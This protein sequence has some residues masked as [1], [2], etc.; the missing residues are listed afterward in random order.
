MIKNIIQYSI[1]FYSIVCVNSI[2]ASQVKM[3]NLLAAG[4]I[5]VIC[6]DNGNTTVILGLEKNNEWVQNPYIDA[7]SGASGFGDSNPL[8]LAMREF[9]EEARLR[10]TVPA[11]NS[12]IQF[13]KDN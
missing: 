10:Y 13:L 7:F 11:L 12:N 2:K 6:Y 3:P 4:V 5:P 8:N 1:F 9:D